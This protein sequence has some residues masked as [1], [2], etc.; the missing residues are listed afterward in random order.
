MMCSPTS[1][2][3]GNVAAAAGRVRARRRFVYP[4]N[5][6]ARPPSLSLRA[7]ACIGRRVDHTDKNA[8][9]CGIHADPR[10]SRRLSFCAREHAA[11]I[12]RRSRRVSE[13]QGLT[14]TQMR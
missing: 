10:W 12:N 7:R 14:A 3:F 9:Q 6:Q 4:Q 1:F 11:N 5:R 8:E 13:I 2:L